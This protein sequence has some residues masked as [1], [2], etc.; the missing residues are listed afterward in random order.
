MCLRGEGH[1]TADVNVICW[2]IG[3]GGS[4]AWEM[5]GGKWGKWLFLV[6]DG[7]KHACPGQGG[8]GAKSES[9]SLSSRGCMCVCVCVCVCVYVCVCVCVCV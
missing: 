8:T 4:T 5:C 6:A 9:L 1:Q 3:W 2:L 7:Y